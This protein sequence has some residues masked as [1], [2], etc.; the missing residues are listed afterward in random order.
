MA[1]GETYPICT[2]PPAAKAPAQGV[3]AP[4]ELENAHQPLALQ[5]SKEKIGEIDF[6][7]HLTE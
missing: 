4:L 7:L 2:Y 3:K 5:A 1:L 6:A